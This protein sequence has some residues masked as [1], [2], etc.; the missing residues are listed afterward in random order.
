MKSE[1]EMKVANDQWGYLHQNFHSQMILGTITQQVLMH[2]SITT[3]TEWLM[4]RRNFF[5]VSFQQKGEK[6]PRRYK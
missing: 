5:S 4:R 2:K 3:L 6:E 1:S